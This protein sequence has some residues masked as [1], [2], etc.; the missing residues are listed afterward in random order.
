MN[1]PTHLVCW[2][3][4]EPKTQSIAFGERFHLFDGAFDQYADAIATKPQ[5]AKTQ[6]TLFTQKWTKTFARGDRFGPKS[7]FTAHPVSRR[8]KNPKKSLRQQ[9]RELGE[10]L[11][12]K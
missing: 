4:R 3:W 12:R 2:I 5:V 6:S 7:L 8:R 11:N 1:P 10:L 9:R